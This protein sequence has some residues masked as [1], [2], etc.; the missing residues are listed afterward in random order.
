MKKICTLILAIF[1][2]L[3]IN[4]LLYAVKEVSSIKI[5]VPYD[6]SRRLSIVKVE[7]NLPIRKGGLQNLVLA[8]EDLNKNIQ[9]NN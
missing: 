6:V 2:F 7:M 4:G 3:G 9:I 5:V 1:I 8:A